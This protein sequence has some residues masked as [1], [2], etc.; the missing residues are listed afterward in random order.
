MNL[1]IIVYNKTRQ[2][3]GHTIEVAVKRK[4][5][6]KQLKEKLLDITEIPLDTQC[7]IFGVQQLD[8]EKTLKQYFI[9]NG[10]TIYLTP[11]YVEVPD[12]PNL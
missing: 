3:A 4:C 9:R 1:K 6:I 8:D 12:M 10:Y 11:T 2:Y 7:L 5:T